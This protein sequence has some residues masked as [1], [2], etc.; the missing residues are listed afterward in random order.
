MQSADPIRLEGNR[1]LC[2]F[3]SKE[4]DK[5]GDVKRH[6]MVHTGEKP[7]ACEYCEY[8][9]TRLQNVTRHQIKCH[10]NTDSKIIF[11]TFRD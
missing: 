11:A 9:S 1:F 6:I 5:L 8:K 2:P 4:F 7:F 10:P 3:C